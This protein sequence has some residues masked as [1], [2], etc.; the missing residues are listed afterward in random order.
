MPEHAGVATRIAAAR[1][2]ADASEAEV[3]ALSAQR[4]KVLKT[5]SPARLM[6]LGRDPELTD[7]DQQ[8]LQNF[9][10]NRARPVAGS[11]KGRLSVS[12]FRR[13]QTGR[14]GAR[15]AT[16][17]VISF[18]AVAALAIGA[19]RTPSDFQ[20][21]SQDFSMVVGDAARPLERVTLRTGSV[22]QLG[23]VSA[24]GRTR[25]ISYWIPKV[26]YQTAIFYPDQSAQ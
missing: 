17:A 26:G 10:A 9:I 16:V 19:W 22:V 11:A 20:V 6:R 2:A 15:R 14:F 21:A 25:E 8:E 12:R 3:Q 7:A 18:F 13:M 4:L 24:D 1:N 5:W 23:P